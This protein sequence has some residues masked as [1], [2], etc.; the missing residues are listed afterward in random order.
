MSKEFNVEDL[1]KHDGK[2]NPTIYVALHGNVFDVTE[3]GMA[4]YGPGKLEI[5]I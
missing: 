1:K 5:L 2:I 3:K 4:N